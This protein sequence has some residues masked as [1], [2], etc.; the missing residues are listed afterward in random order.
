[1]LE[2]FLGSSALTNNGL[3]GES[4]AKYREEF[5]PF[6]LHYLGD[7][8]WFFSKVLPSPATTQDVKLAT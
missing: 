7:V 3:T 5:P 8:S 6:I 1:M 4:N 2:K